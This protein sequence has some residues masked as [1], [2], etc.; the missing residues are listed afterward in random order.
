MLGSTLP[1]GCT[2]YKLLECGT[3]PF[4]QSFYM[5]RQRARE[6]ENSYADLSQYQ[7]SIC[8]HPYDSEMNVYKEVVV[9]S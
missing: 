4:G 5:F 7:Q 1:K 6:L 8:F 2:H 3:V 9:G